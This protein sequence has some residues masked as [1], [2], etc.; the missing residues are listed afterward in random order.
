MSI[1]RTAIRALDTLAAGHV[2]RCHSVP[3]HGSYSVAAH[4]WGVAMILGHVWPAASESLLRAA[5][6]HDVGELWVGDVPSPT[7]RALG[8]DFK[9]RLERLE[10]AARDRAGVGNDP[11]SRDDQARLLFCDRMEFLLWCHRQISMGNS[12]AS[13]AFETVKGYLTASLQET[14]EPARAFFIEVCNL[15]SW[16]PAPSFKVG[17]LTVLPAPT[18]PALPAGVQIGA[19]SRQVGG[20]HYQR[21][22]GRAMQHWDMVVAAGLPYL[23]GNATKYLA[24]WRLKNGKED[25][26]KAAHYIEKL[27]ETGPDIRPPVSEEQIKVLEE[28]KRPY[29]DDP[30]TLAALTFVLFW[31]TKS[32]LRNALNRIN[33][34]LDQ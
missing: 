18:E 21:A 22:A 3:H 7:I 4:S 30:P 32:D 17:D 6:A 31:S 13:A 8:P 27:L 15:L 20:D 26:K 25:L 34:L 16:L 28:F 10:S 11:L 14:P 9:A 23:E 1:R 19:S 29:H 2:E 33:T 12:L 5:L 24:R